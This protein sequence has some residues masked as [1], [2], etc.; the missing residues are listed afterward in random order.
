M[1]NASAMQQIVH[2]E[3]QEPKAA[4]VQPVDG[5]A[6][7]LRAPYMNPLTSRRRARP[8]VITI[9]RSHKVCHPRSTFSSR[10]HIF[11]DMTIAGFVRSNQRGTRRRREHCGRNSD[12]KW[13]EPDLQSSRYVASDDAVVPFSSRA[14]PHLN[15]LH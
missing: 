2:C 15:T 8:S 5:Y 3:R 13:K 14:F 10:Y 7:R 12:C 1:H 11:F 6:P 4:T 9:R